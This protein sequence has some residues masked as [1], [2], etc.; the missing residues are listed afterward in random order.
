MRF[1]FVLLALMSL[2]SCQNEKNNLLPSSTG[3]IN[4]IIFV[5]N[6]D[7]W[8]TNV[9]DTIY[10]MFAKQVEGL[11]WAEPSFDIVQIP[12]SSYTKIFQTHRNIIFLEKSDTNK[13]YFLKNKNS[14][15]QLI[16]VF[17]F[18]NPT[19]LLNNLIINGPKVFNAFKKIELNRLLSKS[20]KTRN[21]DRVFSKHKILFPLLEPFTPVLDTTNFSWLEFSP[22]NKELIK[23]IF[24]FEIPSTRPFDDS[25]FVN[26]LDSIFKNYVL[27]EHKNTYMEIEKN[28]PLQVSPLHI[29]HLYG[30][31]IKG[32][33]KIKNGFM[34]GPFISNALVDSLNNR[35]IFL[36]GFIFNP[37]KPKRN[38]IQEF[39][40]TFNSLKFR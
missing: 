40:A 26:K 38:D 2:F 36:Y 15:D 1:S 27:G 29:K 37:G 11:S 25:I 18:K 33:W 14:K 32:L 35:T 6:N 4:E 39:E 21:L 10:N 31:S 3:A 5:V 13:L 30:H 22:K 8:S 28:Y 17:L 24:I 34:G 7:L 19:D 16:A 23:G 12:L 20:I 9:K